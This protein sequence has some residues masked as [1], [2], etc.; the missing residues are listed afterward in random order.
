[1]KQLLR[2]IQHEEAYREFERS[3]VLVAHEEFLFCSDDLRFG[4][5]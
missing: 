2:T 5:D 1:M 4:Y 3:G